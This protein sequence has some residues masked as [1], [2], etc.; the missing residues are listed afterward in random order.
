MAIGQ[1]LAVGSGAAIGAWIRWGLGITLN[2]STLPLGTLV[3]NLGGGLL[4]G[5]AMAYF[6]AMPQQNELR[7]FVMTGFLGGLTTFSAFSAEAFNFLHKQQYAWAATHI[8][9]H[10]LGSLIMTAIGFMLMSY[11]RR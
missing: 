2:A 4:M 10:V 8:V 9:S 6:I 3:A 5:M 1:W 11:F 7:L